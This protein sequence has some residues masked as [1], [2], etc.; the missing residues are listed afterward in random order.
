MGITKA[1]L[2]NVTSRKPAREAVGPLDGEGGKGE[3][4]GDLEIAEKLN[5]FFASVFTT[6]DLG[7]ILLPE[8]PLLTNELNQIQVKREDFF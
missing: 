1:S 6:E 3:G 5:E 8:Q 2:N 4:K 7:Q